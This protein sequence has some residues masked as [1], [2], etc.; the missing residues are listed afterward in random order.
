MARAGSLKRFVMRDL[1]RELKRKHTQRLAELRAQ[2]KLAKVERK[3]ELK[4]AKQICDARVRSAER[5]AKKAFSAARAAA[6]AAQKAATVK[7]HAA[8]KARKVAARDKCALDRDA[9]KAEASAKVALAKAESAAER[10]DRRAYEAAERT[11]RGRERRQTARTKATRK[12][13]RQESDDLV[14]QN[15]E[16]H[17]WPLWKKRRR[18]VKGRQDLSR[19]EQFMEWVHENPEEVMLAQM[20]AQPSDVQLAAAEEAAWRAAQ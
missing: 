12:E 11:I 20:R 16:P 2:A 18:F 10:E 9:V 8:R 15:I 7:R 14:R 1:E 19:T 6:L 3:R 5:E 13:A 4:L 17:L